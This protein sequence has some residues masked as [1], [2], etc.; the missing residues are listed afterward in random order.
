MLTFSYNVWEVLDAWGQLN[1]KFVQN[2]NSA[3]QKN[4]KFDPQTD[5][6]RVR[7]RLHTKT[8]ILNGSYTRKKAIELKHDPTLLFSPNMIITKFDLH[9]INTLW[10][11]NN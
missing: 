11:G 6:F 8:N 4:T 7:A 9:S 2:L 3:L 10:V 1:S 5:R